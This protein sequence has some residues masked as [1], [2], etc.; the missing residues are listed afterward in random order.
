MTPA[1]FVPANVDLR[2]FPAFMLEVARLRDSDLSLTSTGDEFKAAVLLWAAA[3]H[4]V[5]AGSLPDDERL[6]AA[7]VRLEPKR[8][9]KVRAMAL[10]G[11]TACA[12][13]RLYHSVMAEKALECWISKLNARISSEAGNAKRYGHAF[14][15]TP[16]H[17]E[18]REAGERLRALN[19]K[20]RG[21]SKATR[22]TNA[23]TGS[24]AP[25][26]GTPTGSPLGSQEKGR[27]GNTLPERADAPPDR[28][29]EG[30]DRAVRLLTKAGRM[31]DGP[32]R[33][34]FGKL[35][36]DHGLE[37]SALLPSIVAAEGTGTQ[38]PQGYLTKAAKA[39]SQRSGR[40]ATPA[41]QVADWP[42]EVWQ[43]AIENYTAEGAWSD[44][45][46]PPPGE[47]GCRAPQAVLTAAGLG[48]RVVTGSAA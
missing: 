24:D 15:P 39:V 45:M 30:W 34:F 3:W 35:L 9:L 38:D 1:P 13:G 18:L 29:K 5:P 25:P 2:D 27:E 42:D 36:R 47:P 20:A 46:G 43:R 16:L 23:P 8:W 17:A 11:W 10:R 14:D 31:K 22:Q 26:A 4:Q 12:D 6:L 32:A 41:V 44:T 33:A 21:V 28:N 48:L 7:Y 19:P 37:A 40:A